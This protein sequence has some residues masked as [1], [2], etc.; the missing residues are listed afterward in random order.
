M[1]INTQTIPSELAAAYA[2]LISRKPTAA[3]ATFTA[4]TKP[5]ATSKAAGRRPRKGL[6]DIE[7]A[8][9]F[10]IAYLTKKNGTPPATTFRAAQITAL[11]AGT[12][13]PAYWTKCAEAS[14]TTLE[15]APTSGAFVG[16]RNY[17]YPDP[18]N[19]PSTPTYGAGVPA[20]GD[21]A[22]TGWTT[23]GTF[24]DTGLRWIRKVFTLK[25]KFTRNTPEPLF[26]KLSGNITA[27]ANAR[28]SRAMISAIIKRWIVAAGSARLTTTEAPVIKPISA[29]WRYKTPR[30]IAPY[31][32]LTKPLSLM[33]SARSPD[34]EELTGDLT[35][36]VVLVA[37]MPMMGKR[38]NNNTSIMSTIAATI[39]LWQI[40]K[41]S[42]AGFLWNNLL[43]HEDGITDTITVIT[44]PTFMGNPTHGFAMMTDPNT[45]ENS[46]WLLDGKLTATAWVPDWTLAPEWTLFDYV[47]AVNYHASGYIVAT[48]ATYY[49]NIGYWIVAL[50]GASMQFIIYNPLLI[51]T[52]IAFL[53][54]D[55]YVYLPS[56]S[57]Y[58]FHDR[59][60]SYEVSVKL[61]DADGFLI[62]ERS[63]AP[64][65]YYF[66]RKIITSLTKI[67]MLIPEIINAVNFMHVWDLQQSSQTLVVTINLGNSAEYGFSSHASDIYIF[68]TD[69]AQQVVK[70]SDTGSYSTLPNNVA[71]RIRGATQLSM[72]WIA[73][74]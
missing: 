30:G 18:A 49:G 27:T 15:N 59:G 39:E 19:Q 34:Y 36:A 14:S 50:D 6:S 61:F 42:P 40:R 25:N 3:G 2:K 12:F 71:G 55:I 22:Y 17:A 11:K 37:P 70:I 56:A 47:T 65:A 5:R 8:V 58:V 10:L 16:I 69:A 23:A 67:Y 66:A 62:S 20:T 1:K 31:F 74:E 63:S 32:A 9:D 51:Q 13:D 73:N 21:P 26:L 72:Q 53:N 46:W 52:P 24:A 44:Y 60:A 38:F 33:Y 7:S 48:S 28:P 35:S 64:T 57:A 45:D 54:Q 43:I 4:R 41:T 29:F 68:P